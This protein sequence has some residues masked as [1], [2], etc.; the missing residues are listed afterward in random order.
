M[1]A[2]L[3]AVLDSAQNTY[4]E[5]RAASD[6]LSDLLEAMDEVYGP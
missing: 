5:I 4:N 6:G 2:E 1:M 3:E